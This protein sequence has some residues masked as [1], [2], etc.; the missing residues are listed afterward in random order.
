MHG[1]LCLCLLQLCCELL[2]VCV[3][4]DMDMDMDMMYNLKYKTNKMGYNENLA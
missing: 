2:K 3:S 4:M 1:F